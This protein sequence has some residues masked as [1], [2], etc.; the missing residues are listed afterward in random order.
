M[1]PT[2]ITGEPLPSDAPTPETS[3]PQ[4][5]TVTNSE[6]PG[7]QVPS[8]ARRRELLA[9]RNFITS[10]SPTLRRLGSLTTFPTTVSGVLNISCSPFLYRTATGAAAHSA[11]DRRQLDPIPGETA[12]VVEKALGV[13]KEVTS[14][15]SAPGRRSVVAAFERQTA[16]AEQLSLRGGKIV[17][18]DSDGAAVTVTA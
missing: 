10:W 1:W 4:Q 15:A 3:R 2:T 17:W 13:D 11:R 14:A 7:S 5:L 18:P 8:A 6:L 9:T 12:G 16:R